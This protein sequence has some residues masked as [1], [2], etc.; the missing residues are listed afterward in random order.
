M[1]TEIKFF[2]PEKEEIY[3]INII[4]F[5]EIS[6][7]PHWYIKTLKSKQYSHKKKFDYN[8]PICIMLLQ[9]KIKEYNII[10]A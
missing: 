7:Y 4:P 1:E 2:S 5:K 6:Y 8:C 10:T 3:K 9:R